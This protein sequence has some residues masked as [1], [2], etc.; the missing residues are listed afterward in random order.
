MHGYEPPNSFDLAILP[1]NT[2]YSIL[3]CLKNLQNVRKTLP[4][5]LQKAQNSQKQNFDKKRQQISFQP[6]DKVLL[7]NDNVPKDKNKKLSPKYVGPYSIV[8]KINDLNYIINMEKFNKATEEVVHISKL[9]R[10]FEP[11]STYSFEKV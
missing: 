10:F 8:K 7:L 5:I 11:F 2:D 3:D 1:E 6:G 9:K 4:T